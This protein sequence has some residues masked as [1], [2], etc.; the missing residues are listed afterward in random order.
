M[1][2]EKE[3]AAHRAC[4]RRSATR[5]RRRWSSA[6]TNQVATIKAGKAGAGPSSSGPT[7][8]S[9]FQAGAAPGAMMR[10]MGLGGFGGDMGPSAEDRNR[11]LRRSIAGAWLSWRLM[12]IARGIRV[13]QILSAS[14]TH[15]VQRGNA[16]RGSPQVLQT[17]DR[18]RSPPLRG[19]SRSMLILAGWSKR[20]KQIPI[21][22]SSSLDLDSIPLIVAEATGPGLLYDGVLLI[23]SIEGISD[24]S[25][26]S[27]KSVKRRAAGEGAESSAIGLFNDRRQFASALVLRPTA[28]IGSSIVNCDPSPAGR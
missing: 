14:R 5:R 13:F 15:F 9:G 19:E 10:G 28:E 16:T 12:R 8:S 27:S 4:S 22:R 6:P 23:S 17:G 18:D 20:K 24:G 2:H 26:R 3:E 21:R 11:R 25:A 7:A 1:E